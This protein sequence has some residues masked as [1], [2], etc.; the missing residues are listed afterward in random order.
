MTSF[1][2][3]ETSGLPGGRGLTRSPAGHAPDLA[4]FV[5]DESPTC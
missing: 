1:A 2:A 5:S 4:L 3:T